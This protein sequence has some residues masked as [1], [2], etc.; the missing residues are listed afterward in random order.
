MSYQKTAT[1]KTGRFRTLKMS[2]SWSGSATVNSPFGHYPFSFFGD[3]YSTG[4]CLTLLQTGFWGVNFACGTVPDLS[5]GA[6]YGGFLP[7][8]N[9]A[10]A[11]SVGWDTALQPYLTPI[12]AFGAADSAQVLDSHSP[13]TYDSGGK[14]SWLFELDVEEYYDVYQEIDDNTGQVIFPGYGGK[15]QQEPPY[16]NKVVFYELTKPGGIIH[17][18]AN[19]T[20]QGG[21]FYAHGNSFTTEIKAYVNAAIPAI[22]T[23]GGLFGCVALKAGYAT[24]TIAFNGKYNATVTANMSAVF[25]NTFSGYS[26][27]N[28]FDSVRDHAGVGDLTGSYS[29]NGISHSMSVTSNTSGANPSGQVWHTVLFSLSLPKIVNVNAHIFADKNDYPDQLN[30]FVAGDKGFDTLALG[31]GSASKTITQGFALVESIFEFKASYVYKQPPQIVAY[32]NRQALAAWVS[33]G[34]L[35]K[36]REPVGDWRMMWR[37]IPFPAF[38]LEQKTYM[39]VD[40]TFPLDQRRVNANLVASSIT[41]WLGAGVG[42]SISYHIG[43]GANRASL[44]DATISMPGSWAA[45]A[46]ATVSSASSILTI[47]VPDGNV[48]GGA[49]RSFNDYNADFHGT[50]FGGYRRLRF[51][52]RASIDNAPFRVRLSNEDGSKYW[53]T[54][55]G[56]LGTFINVDIDLCNPNDRS[57]QSDTTDSMWPFVGESLSFHIKDGDY[58]GVTHVSSLSLENLQ[59]AV[60]Y[61]IDSITLEQ[62]K[63]P[64]ISIAPAF[65]NLVTE[66]DSDPLSDSLRVR[67]VM[68]DTGGVQSLEATDLRVDV[69][70]KLTILSIEALRKNCDLTRNG[71]KAIATADANFPDSYHKNSLNGVHLWG[72]GALFASVGTDKT[73]GW[74]SGFDRS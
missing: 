46:P 23:V 53:D 28:S 54:L 22:Y 34:T 31:S 60:V 25:D 58:T 10:V 55:T 38:T 56:A 73:P 66:Y 30:V 39:V 33:P 57:P 1:V 32:D 51:N 62:I 68:A 42:K 71:W 65:N 45:I 24:S 14:G 15:T 2:G 3:A 11:L 9:G 43:V 61:D 19:Y 48:K 29:T 7:F 70:G 21:N 27:T 49:V 5:L 6:D 18:S 37:G 50:S 4:H 69:E 35:L 59:N 20:A 40:N 52:I 67:S 72:A 64:T 13:T 74:H 63:P 17:L 36:N 8:P 41:N 47:T 26:L 12:T 16:S 44:V